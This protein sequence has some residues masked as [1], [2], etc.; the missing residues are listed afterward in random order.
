MIL[1]ANVARIRPEILRSADIDSELEMA[2]AFAR[3]SLSVV[4][5][6]R[7]CNRWYRSPPHDFIVELRREMPLASRGYDAA[8]NV[9]YTLISC[10]AKKIIGVGNFHS[11]D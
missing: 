8:T 4:K 3:E 5:F 9:N 2:Y 7:R 1:I 10:S 6:N 11:A